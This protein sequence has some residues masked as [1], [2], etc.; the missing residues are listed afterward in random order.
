MK[1]I[2]QTFNRDNIVK[3]ILDILSIQSFT[4]N[5]LGITKC[6]NFI[7]SLAKQ[8]G[9][10]VSK[11]GKG[12]VLVISPKYLASTPALG[13]VVHLDTVPFVANQWT[14]SPLGEIAN[15]RIY[16]RGVLDDKAAIILA[17]HAFKKLE[18]IIKPSWQIIVGSSEESEWTDMYEFLKETPVLPKFMITVDG[19]GVQNGCRGCLNLVLKF[20]RNSKTKNLE[21]LFIPNGVE[22][23]VPDKAIAV[24][25]KHQIFENG[26]SVH[27]S[28]PEKGQN[29]F[30]RLIRR[31]SLYDS[32][33]C[34]FP[35]FF[36]LMELLE[37]GNCA[38]LLGFAPDT[39]IC[40]T[41]CNLTEDTLSVNYNIRLGP[42][43]AQNDLFR[44]LEQILQNYH[45]TMDISSLTFPSC[46]SK[47]SKEIQLMCESYHKVMGKSTTPNIA[48]GL[49]YNAAFP[50]CA[51]FGPR[52]APED[53]EPDTC[54]G[55]DENRKIEDLLKFLDMLSIFIYELLK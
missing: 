53:D 1:K 45:C 44:V 17:L 41:K 16:G 54:H 38:E 25:C 55:I 9:F 39:S 11:H 20:M 33:T 14:Y 6:Q 24:A 4:D 15:E 32:I 50:N 13:I 34:E 36:E 3:D 8:M 27:S 22:N 12:K 48:R 49:G 42:L 5:P 28:I 30:S 26:F 43:T 19:D 2:V 18:N 23:I 29:A 31:L 47:D 52:F 7:I 40:P 21:Q 46:V 35:Y 37:K 10:E 51:I